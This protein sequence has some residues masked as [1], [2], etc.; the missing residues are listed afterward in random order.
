MTGRHEKLFD[1]FFPVGRRN[2]SFVRLRAFY[3]QS[4]IQSAEQASQK[5]AGKDFRTSYLKRE[6]L[7]DSTECTQKVLHGG[8]F[9]GFFLGVLNYSK[10][11]TM[12]GSRKITCVADILNNK[13]R[14]DCSWTEA[15]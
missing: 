6:P 11:K 15:T 3:H 13:L 9:V 5:R 12:G 14:N 7:S 4:F 8:M 1:R 10:I 2:V